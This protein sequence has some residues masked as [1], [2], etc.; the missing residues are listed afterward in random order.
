MNRPASTPE[1]SPDG[2]TKLALVTGAS[3]GIG[4]AFALRLGADGY[5]L[6]VVGRRRERLDELVAALPDVEVRPLVADLGTDAGVE[7]VADVCAREALTMLVNNAGVAHY[8][9]FT[10]L[11]ADKASELLH[12]KV[13]A[14]TLL[15]RAAAPGMVARGGGTLVNVSGMLAFSGPASME[16]L[17]LRRA[18]YTATLAHIV[19]LSQALHEELKSQGLRVQALC[20]GVVA[21]EFHQRQG[22]DLSAVPRM[23][24]DDVVTASLRGLA[25]GEIVCAPGVDRSDLLEAVFSADLAAFAAQAPRLAERYRTSAP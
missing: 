11:P 18:V 14:P 19:A 21:T 1:R 3:S 22:L 2:R 8:M 7:A 6:V 10:E 17:P 15:A 4:R 23:S 5:D 13:V 24:A 12:V 16:K 9:P 25:L 20:P